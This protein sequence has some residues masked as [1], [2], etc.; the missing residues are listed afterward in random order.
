MGSIHQQQVW[1]TGVDI[2]L[3]E[4]SN[5]TLSRCIDTLKNTLLRC[6]PRQ[7]HTSFSNQEN[8]YNPS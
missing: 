8:N 6:Y 1:C 3:L 5:R 4:S 7:L 2:V